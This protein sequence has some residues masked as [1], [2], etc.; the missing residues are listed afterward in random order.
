M[1][2]SK[3][4]SLDASPRELNE[5]E[6]RFQEIDSE[7]EAIR[8]T[9]DDNND[10]ELGSPDLSL[11]ESRIDELESAEKK[12]MKERHR[13]NKL[14][15]KK[16]KGK[17]KTLSSVVVSED[18]RTDLT[19]VERKT[20]SSGRNDP[21]SLPVSPQTPSQQRANALRSSGGLSEIS[22]QLRI[23][24][25][26]NEAQAVE[27]NR[28]ERQLR[29]LA[30]LQGIN[31][32][33]LRRA[34]EQACEDE[35]Y[36]ELQHRIAKLQAELE[37]A[38][39]MQKVGNNSSNQNKN[40]SA[41]TE[42]LKSKIAE[43]QS[44]EARYKKKIDELSK[45]VKEKDKT[46]SELMEAGDKTEDEDRLKQEL[47]KMSADQ[48]AMAELLQ[49]KDE[50][51]KATRAELDAERQQA[52]QRRRDLEVKTLADISKLNDDIDKE[53]DLATSDGKSSSKDNSARLRDM[54]QQ[55]KSLYTAVGVLSEDHESDKAKHASLKNYLN[56]ADSAVARQMD[57]AQK[58]PKGT[59]QGDLY[60]ELL[61][62]E[63]AQL[64]GAATKHPGQKTG[65][66]EQRRSV[67]YSISGHL[68]VRSNGL[69]RKWKTKPARLHFFYG[70]Y[71][72]D[73]GDKSY[74]ITFGISKVIHNP[75]HPLS[76]TIQTDPLAGGTPTIQVAASSENDYARW[77][78][79]L[80]GAT[81]GVN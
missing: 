71:R 63:Y 76:F 35:A 54:E 14:L 45:I 47:L 24:Q 58:S 12:L 31:V 41:E 49:Q 73:L 15:R 57:D 26:K 38:T 7:I 59:G 64:K 77:I 36:G 29:L 48:A 27:I 20:S 39:L 51:L 16:G 52:E 65:P 13:L 25:A 74:P 2:V 11:L 61:M 46:I 4:S 62:H 34:L 5:Y 17:S 44:A 78:S 68:L 9:F 67:D 8:N 50:A 75:D 66:L 42:A 79:A 37:A 60:R 30:D 72:L 53:K 32:K 56:E 18:S 6:D 1:M 19:E 43:L 22:K 80:D 40:N 33:D 55:L 3:S 81:T 23:S 10:D 69:V 70:R 28:L 21:A